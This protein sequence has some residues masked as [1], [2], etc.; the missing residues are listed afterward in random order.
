[1]AG[2]IGKNGQ[3][4]QRPNQQRLRH[5]NA[6]FDTYPQMRGDAVVDME[7]IKMIESSGKKNAYNTKS[8]ARGYYQITPI[9]V[10]EWNNFHKNDKLAVEDM[11]D[12][13]TSYKVASWYMNK[14]IPQ[15]LRRYRKPD[16]LNNRL[17]A[18]NAGISYVRDN[19]PLPSQTRDYIRK[20]AGM[21]GASANIGQEQR[22]S[23]F[24]QAFRNARKQGLNEFIY[25]GKRYN[26]K[27]RGE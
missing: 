25:N 18:Y 14:R 19:K 10:E 8:Q 1:V 11:F 3:A 16:T 2:N 17:I 15:M 9:V 7:K 4:R 22:I 12:S 27:M 26:T 21:G 23:P 13:S 6:S 24:G 5:K 20:Y